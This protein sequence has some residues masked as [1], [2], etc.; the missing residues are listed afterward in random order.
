MDRMNLLVSDLDG[1]LIGDGRALREFAD[2][3][4]GARR[5][6]SPCVHFGPVC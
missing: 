4:D 5:S 3:F 6:V 1:T 2:W